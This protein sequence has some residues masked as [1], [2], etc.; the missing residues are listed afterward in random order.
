MLALTTVLI[1]QSNEVFEEIHN[2][3]FNSILPDS[4]LILSL[5]INRYDSKQGNEVIYNLRNKIKKE[6]N[7]NILANDMLNRSHLGLKGLHFNRH[8]IKVMTCNIFSFTKQ[9]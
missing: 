5:P 2:L 3:S 4:K 6:S 7:Y 8:G 1:K 9:L